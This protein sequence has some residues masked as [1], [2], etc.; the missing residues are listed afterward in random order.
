M[1]EKETQGTVAELSLRVARLEV[2]LRISRMM[3]ATTDQET[4]IANIAGEVEGCVK[5]DR[6]SVFF[7][8]RMED[9]LYTH[10]ATG[11]S[12]GQQIRI[13][14]DAGIAGTVFQSGEPLNVPDVRQEPRFTGEADRKTGYETRN[15]LTF[16]L[17]NRRGRSIGVFQLL[18]KQG[19]PGYFTEEDEAFLA[20]LVDQIADLLD[21]IL[22]KDELARR[23]AVLEAQMA[24]LSSFEYLIGD[25][26]AINTLF[27]YNRKIHYWLGFGGLAFLGLMAITS[28]GMVHSDGL[29]KVM[30]GLHIGTEFRLGYRYYLYTDAISVLTLILC[31]SGLLIYVYPPLNRWLKAQKARMVAR[32]LKVTEGAP[33]DGKG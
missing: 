2:L 17:K 26:T 31:G 20:E 27:R 22:R 28:I 19:E 18:N 8:D 3:N 33:D 1:P 30:L 16:P 29:R 5:A 10:L 15:M 24:Q 9:E 6:C 13:P 32:K 4:L 25:R 7:Y 23:N 11:L 14:S 21:L 12:A